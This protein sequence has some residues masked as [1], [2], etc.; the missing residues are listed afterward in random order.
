MLNLTRWLSSKSEEHLTDERIIA[1]IDDEDD[2]PCAIACVKP[3]K[4]TAKRVI[5]LDDPLCC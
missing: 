5:H 3:Q 4:K 2:S 1:I